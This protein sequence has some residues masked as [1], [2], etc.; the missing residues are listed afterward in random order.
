MEKITSG[1]QLDTIVHRSN[2]PYYCGSGCNF[3]VEGNLE[4]SND[5]VKKT[6]NV[7]VKNVGKMDNSGPPTQQTH[8]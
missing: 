8:I 7:K 4:I 5:Q 2:K 3:Q 6:K 1:S